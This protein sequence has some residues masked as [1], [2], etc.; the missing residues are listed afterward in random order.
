MLKA[1]GKLC[2]VCAQGFVVRV[3]LVFVSGGVGGRGRGALAPRSILTVEG[4]LPFWGMQ[5]RIYVCVCVS[6]LAGLLVDA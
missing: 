4:S 3:G 5:P 2:V 1:K 6:V